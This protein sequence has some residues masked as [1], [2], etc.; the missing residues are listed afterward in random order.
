M[1][2]KTTIIIILSILL[3]GSLFFTINFKQENERLAF[4][5]N[6]LIKNY[7]NCELE[8][9]DLLLKLN[10]SKIENKENKELLNIFDMSERIIFTPTLKKVKDL[11]KKDKTDEM[12]YLTGDFNCVDFSY[13]LI[14]AF[15]H[16]NI[17]SCTTSIYFEDGAHEIV[18]LK[19]IENGLIYIEPQNDLIIYELK[20]GDDYC[21]KVD[22]DCEWEITK[23]KTCFSYL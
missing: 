3:F 12:E 19:T 13:T 21:E 7:S 22:W 6:E 17:Y 1:I 8:K 15:K 9:S 14:G 11:L 16:E 4:D 2:S 18:A 20:A 5:K 23:I 10:F